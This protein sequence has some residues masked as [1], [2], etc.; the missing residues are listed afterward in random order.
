M[1]G[2]RF[3]IEVFPGG[4]I[5]QPLDDIRRRTLESVEGRSPGG[6]H[7][8]LDLRLSKDVGGIDDGDG[9]GGDERAA[10]RHEESASFSHRAP[11]RAEDAPRAD[12]TSRRT[13]GRR[14]R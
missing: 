11:Y 5:M 3:R 14:S 2:G 6:G 1:S 13:G 4:Q 8:P 12:L 9:G 7:S 10:R